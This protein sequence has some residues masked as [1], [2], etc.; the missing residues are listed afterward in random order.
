MTEWNYDLSQAP[1]GRC[2]TKK[3]K[4]KDKVVEKKVYE[5][6]LI[7][8]TDGRIVTLTKWLPPITTGPKVRQRGGRW[9]MFATNETPL[10]WMPW[11]NPPTA[12]LKGKDDE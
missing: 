9:S 2:V 4:V 10:A 5:Y 1:R 12:E 8:A 11:P 3:T 6:D 7:I